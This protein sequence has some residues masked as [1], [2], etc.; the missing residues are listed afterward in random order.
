MI[1]T[2]IL[3]IGNVLARFG[4]KDYLDVCGYSEETIHKVAN[5]TVL[6]PVWRMW[7]CGLRKNSELVELCCRQ[8]LSVEKEIRKFF[9]DLFTIVKEFDYSAEFVRNLKEAGYLVYLLS[10]Y[11]REHFQNDSKNFKFYPYVD[12]Q[13]ISYEISHGKPEAIIYETLI[14]KYRID[15]TKSVFLDDVK[16]NLDG[17]APFGFATIQVKSQEQAV[18]DLRKLGVRI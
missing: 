9:E 6:S 5:A 13:V 12:G 3:D 17:A 4:W 2:V 15:P 10:N 1:N 8:D 16:E 11:N 18:E 14:Q 7:D